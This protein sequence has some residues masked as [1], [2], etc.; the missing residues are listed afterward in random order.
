MKKEK[1]EEILLGSRHNTNR[2]Q[3]KMYYI[4]AGYG[5]F[6]LLNVASH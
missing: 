3:R 6:F 4:T 1:I 2:K 5:V